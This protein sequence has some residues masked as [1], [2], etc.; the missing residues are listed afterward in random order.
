MNPISPL[1][2]RWPCGLALALAAASPVAQAAWPERPV[3]LVVPFAPGGGTDQVARLLAA[4]LSQA[5]NQ[6]VVVENKPGAG[7]VIGTD[8]VA[9]SPPDGYAVLVATFS[10]AINPSLLD[11]LPYDTATAFAPVVLIARGPNV[12]VVPATSAYKTVAELLAGARAAPKGL[13]FASQGNGTSAHLAGE[14]LISLTQANL[15]HVPYKGAGPALTDLIGGQVDMMFATAAAVSKHV[16]AG[17]LRALAV[18]SPEQS[19]SFP[20]VSTVAQT[21]PGYA[22]ESWYGLFVPAGTPASVV[23]RLNEAARIAVRRDDFRVKVESEGL[24]ISASTPAELD[25]YVNGE[26]ARWRKV[27][28]DMKTKGN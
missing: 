10:H 23:N 28:S 17:K 1:S 26:A 9:K 7:T 8:L 12:L 22:V 25:Q 6:S 20:G 11:K 4:G 5:L 16:S 27:I 21:V 24:S 15:L 19:A 3:R 14:M 2:A 13:T 18:T